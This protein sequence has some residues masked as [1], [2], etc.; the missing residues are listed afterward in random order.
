MS[1]HLYDILWNFA[2]AVLYRKRYYNEDSTFPDQVF[3]KAYGMIKSNEWELNSKHRDSYR[4]EPDRLLAKFI[5]P[6]NAS[7]EKV[8]EVF[9]TAELRPK[10]D[11]FVSSARY[12]EKHGRFNG[13]HYLKWDS[14]ALF[15]MDAAALIHRRDYPNGDIFYVGTSVEHSAVPVIKESKRMKAKIAGILTEKIDD[16]HCRFSLF[17]K[18]STSITKSDFIAGRYYDTV[19]GMQKMFEKK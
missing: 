4:Y 19:C 6:V 7:T 15:R 3:D 5:M 9:G 18:T 14:L 10:W 17:Y 11:K 1:P 13:I 12:I 8:A 2:Q 16:D